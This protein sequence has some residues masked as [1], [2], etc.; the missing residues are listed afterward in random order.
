MIA[1]FDAR[2]LLERRVLAKF[3]RERIAQRQ[4]AT[5]SNRPRERCAREHKFGQQDEMCSRKIGD[6]IAA[7]VTQ[8]SC[9]DISREWH[10]VRSPSQT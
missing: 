8:G 7:A 3:L 6:E 9:V 10:A 5:P 2:L 1:N 4:T